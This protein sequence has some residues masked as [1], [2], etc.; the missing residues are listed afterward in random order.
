MLDLEWYDE[1]EMNSADFCG[2]ARTQRGQDYRK[3]RSQVSENASCWAGPSMH[4]L[5][6][7]SNH[8]VATEQV[9]HAP[10]CLNRQVH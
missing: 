10:E 1:N 5:T 7:A 3:F 4:V 6:T 8:Q 9:S 2:A